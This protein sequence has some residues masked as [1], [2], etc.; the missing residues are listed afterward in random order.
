[1]LATT[2]PPGIA[3][4]YEDPDIQELMPFA[5]LD[6]VAGV[7]PRPSYSTGALYNEVS[8]LYFSAVHSVLTGE[9]DAD[10]AMELLELELMDLLGSE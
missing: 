1:A 6:V 10:V 9:E 3:A 2:S 4:L 5:T 8:T 7:T